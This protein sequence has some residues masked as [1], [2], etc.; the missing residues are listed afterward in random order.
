[1]EVVIDPN[2][3]PAEDNMQPV[4]YN[5]ESIDRCPWLRGDKPGELSCAVHDRPW[6]AESPCA[7]YQSH[8]PDDRPCTLGEYI[9]NGHGKG[10]FQ[11]A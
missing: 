1:M 9:V 2:I 8:W 10:K 7:A 4:G 5:E 6:Y 3:G 11:L